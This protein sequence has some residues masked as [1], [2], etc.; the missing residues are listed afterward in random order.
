MIKTSTMKL[1]SSSLLLLAAAQLSAAPV[2][3]SG[4]LKNAPKNA[5]VSV[6]YTN[7]GIEGESVSLAKTK[8]DDQGKFSVTFEWA[9]A[10]SASIKIGDQYTSMFLHPN[11]AL[12]L[13]TDYNDFDVALKYSG[14]GGADNQ[15]VADELNKNFSGY[16]RQI[17][18]FKDATAYTKFIDSCQAVHRNFVNS[19]AKELSPE[20][21]ADQNA[22]VNYG[23]V[24]ARYLF[25]MTFDQKKNEIQYKELPA[26][27]FAF[28]DK[29]NL[30]D[31][32]SASSEDYHDAIE[33][34]FAEKFD[35]NHKYDS[36][37]AALGEDKITRFKFNNR[38]QY[39]QG[40]I[41]DYELTSFMADVIRDGSSLK[42]ADELMPEYKNLVRNPELVSIVDR[43]YNSKARL[44]PGQPAPELS[45]VDL[46]GKT[47]TLADLKGK[48]V[49]VDFWATWCGPCMRAMPKEEELMKAYAGRTDMAF[50]MV[51][52]SDTEDRWKK[53]VSDKK[54]GGIHWFASGDNS[55][56]VTKSYNF[57]GI[58]HWVLIDKDG[59]FLNSN[60]GGIEDVEREVNKL[61]N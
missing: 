17:Q 28:L 31:E 44:S 36:L 57:N 29:V 27:Y 4:E 37:K 60:V 58:P 43:I 45:L 52:V 20:L 34:V 18:N 46:N 50:L 14:V 3:I 39:L 23:Y 38:V 19:R 49:L 40:S 21:L 10:G 53:Y 30:N 32:K 54:P 7:N 12:T 1:L 26:S 6:Y 59:K 41:R 35:R 15:Y 25:R 51:N 47:T 22:K 8:L 2:T 5:K 33:Q 16:Q 13:K 42:A 24:Y 56:A 48:Y 9:K 61:L 55:S 11:D